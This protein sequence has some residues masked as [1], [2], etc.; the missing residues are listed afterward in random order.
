VIPLTARLSMIADRDTHS[1]ALLETLL[2]LALPRLTAQFVNGEFV[3]TTIG[4][5]APGGGWSLRTAGR[6]ARYAAIVALGLLRVSE[7]EQRYS[8]RW[9]SS[10]GG[11][12]AVRCGATGTRLG[13]AT[14]AAAVER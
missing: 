12:P 14:R 1:A 4:E 13:C 2:K 5:A 7:A 6:S 10:R 11:G 8:W 3:F 9:L